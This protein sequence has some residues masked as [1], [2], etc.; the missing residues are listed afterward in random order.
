ML[1]ILGYA[2]GTIG[3]KDLKREEISWITVVLM[4]NGLFMCVVCDISITVI[5]FKVAF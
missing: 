4:L 1:T 2:V 5:L 3:I